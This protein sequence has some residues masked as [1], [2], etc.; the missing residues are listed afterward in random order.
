MIKSTSIKLL[1]IT[2]LFNQQLETL[3]NTKEIGEALGLSEEDIKNPVVIEIP[4]GTK[5]FAFPPLGK[6]I[7]FETQRIRVSDKSG[8]DLSESKLV[9]DFKKIF[10]K[11]APRDSLTAYGYNYDILFSTEKP[12]Q[13][14]HLLGDRIL[15]TLS[16][17]KILESGVRVISKKNNIRFDLQLMPS[18][19]PL[20]SILHLNV[21]FDKN[22]IPTDLASDFLKYY[23]ETMNILSQF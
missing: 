7:I 13:P 9:E 2:V 19:N 23:K 1:N 20:Q 6:E 15:K 16:G 10:E 3:P 17:S 4:G 18:G 5:V 8:K 21:H 14:K 11:F 12:L 22:I